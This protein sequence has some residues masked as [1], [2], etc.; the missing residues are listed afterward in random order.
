MGGQAFGEIIV[1][2]YLIPTMAGSKNI[3][4]KRRRRRNPRSEANKEREAGRLRKRVS[5]VRPRACTDELLEDQAVFD[6]KLLA[7]LPTDAAEEVAAIRNALAA[8]SEGR[9]AEA[10]R[11]VSTI[12]R[13][14]QRSDWRLFVRGLIDWYHDDFDGAQRSW[15]RLDPARRPAS[16]AEKLLGATPQAATTDAGAVADP[17]LHP[18]VAL[19]QR[20]RFD[21]VA[22]AEA[23]RETARRE[24]SPGDVSQ[25]DWIGPIKLRWLMEFTTDNRRTEPKLVA[26]LHR[27]ALSRAFQTDYANIFEV[28][29]K[30]LAGPAHD[31]KN[32]LL[33]FQY[34]DRFDNGERD[35]QVS[36]DRYLKDLQT[37]TQLTENVRAALTSEVHLMLAQRE[38]VPQRGSMFSFV[39]FGEEDRRSIKKHFQAATKAYPASAAAHQDYIEWIRSYA[40]D[41][42]ARKA[43]RE[44]FEKKIPAA[45]KAWSL[46]VP[47]AIEPRLWL[48]D[49][50]LE[51]EETDS[52]APH[53][54]WLAA[55][56][57]PDPRVRAI[58]WKWH[59]LE[60]MRLGRR[61]AWLGQVAEHLDAAES[62]WPS[63]V[64]KSWMPY[65]RAALAL[66]GG[67]QTEYE[68]L[69]QAARDQ[70]GS[71]DRYDLV[72]A[73]MMLGAAQRFRIPN[74]ELKLFRQPIDH[75]VKN[76]SELTD[77]QLLACGKFFLDL[78]RTGLLYPA[79][80][81]HGGKFADELNR[82]LRLCGPLFG[83]EIDDDDEFWAA[84]FWLT[85][86]RTFAYNYQV[87][88]PEIVRRRGD[89][90]RL[91]AIE[92]HVT[93]GSSFAAGLD[94][95]IAKVQQLKE[96]AATEPDGYLRYW[97]SSIAE[98]AEETMEKQSSAFDL[99]GFADL[100]SRAGAFGFDDEKD[101][102]D[103]EVIDPNDY[104][105]QC[106]CQHCTEVRDRL[107]VPHP[108]EQDD[109]E[110]ERID[111]F[112]MWDDSPLT[113][114]GP[115]QDLSPNIEPPPPPRSRAAPPPPDFEFRSKRPKNPMAKKRGK[116]NKKG[117]KR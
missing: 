107:G 104:D 64:A 90:V 82:R 3:K 36:I 45:M 46:G 41:D 31:P 24:D 117:R 13:R 72:D 50:Y 12:P 84:V 35:A 77:K 48:V 32:L 114:S 96:S 71:D 4:S 113:R 102:D 99:G 92:L 34:H 43:E 79:Y 80:R 37:N 17:N 78:H 98:R 57:H 115:P 65:L 26:A 28:A 60:A 95:Q 40:E 15:Q 116:K 19:V 62:M 54:E 87:K 38:I 81:M 108:W 55:S 63:W 86:K 76:L 85:E 109:Q 73:A 61:K 75:A 70:L 20:L 88:I 106:D 39:N 112:D 66:R 68:N 47:D 16:I 94:R 58:R 2:C 89:A 111:R 11:H 100:F 44:P 22:L 49:Y 105:P 29:A 53:V 110:D 9:D 42:R 83:D 74:A 59:L 93:L 69:R 56:R 6:D 21:R 18:G 103:D 7:K 23:R 10:A 52:A 67:E 101:D 25:E 91:A 51:N 1:S 14:S 27:A 97:Y 8:V 5:R 30:K 33:A